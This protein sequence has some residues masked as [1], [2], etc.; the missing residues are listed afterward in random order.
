MGSYRPYSENS[1]RHDQLINRRKLPIKSSAFASD[2]C[3]IYGMHDCLLPRRKRAFSAAVAMPQ[4]G[5]YSQTSY[6]AIQ[7]LA[8]AYLLSSRTSKEGRCHAEISRPGFL[9]G[10]R[11]QG[12]AEGG[13]FETASD[14]R[15]TRR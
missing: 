11:S 15:K 8:V 14:G 4:K 5:N 9:H 3:D 12:L 13:R 1:G 6:S 2:L 7:L 10:S